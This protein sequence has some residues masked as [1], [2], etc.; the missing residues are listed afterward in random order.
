MIIYARSNIRIF[1]GPRVSPLSSTTTT[2]PQAPT[3]AAEVDTATGT[4]QRQ[5]QLPGEVEG[6]ESVL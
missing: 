5:A 4:R 6:E 1:R 2:K 3:P